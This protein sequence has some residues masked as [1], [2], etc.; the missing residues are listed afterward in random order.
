[1]RPVQYLRDAWAEL[2]KVKWPTRA[3]TIQYSLIVLLSVTIAT[4]FFGG[5]DYAFSELI[6]KLFIRS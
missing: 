2:G 3:L 1:M 5:I 6:L 4:A